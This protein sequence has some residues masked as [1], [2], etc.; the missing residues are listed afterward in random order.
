MQASN[1]GLPS[2]PHFHTPL[3]DEEFDDLAVV[4]EAPQLPNLVML[5]RG[6]VAEWIE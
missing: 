3:L 4:N 5:S 1:L 2:I 6:N